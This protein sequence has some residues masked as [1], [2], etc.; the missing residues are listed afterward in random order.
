M[1][2]DNFI[3]PSLTTDNVHGIL[4]VSTDPVSF[5][6]DIGMCMCPFL[7]PVLTTGMNEAKSAN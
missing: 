4:V 7:R 5:V 1:V 6:H 2:A 3:D